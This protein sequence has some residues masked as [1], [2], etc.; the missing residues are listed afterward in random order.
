MI[1]LRRNLGVY[2]HVQVRYICVVY[3]KSKNMY[4]DAPRDDGADEFQ[5]KYIFNS[6]YSS[7]AAIAIS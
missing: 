7:T 1:I 4:L 5:Y 6:L 3:N 2:G